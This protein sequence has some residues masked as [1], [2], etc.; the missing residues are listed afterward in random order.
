MNRHEKKQEKKQISIDIN[1]L[2]WNS[3]KSY[4]HRHLFEHLLTIFLM[5]QQ[6]PFVSFDI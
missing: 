2:V 3:L 5:Y 1:Q 4:L 6:E